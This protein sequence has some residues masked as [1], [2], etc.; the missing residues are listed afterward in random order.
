[1]SETLQRFAPIDWSTCSTSEAFATP[2]WL[3][4]V[5]DWGLYWSFGIND[6]WTKNIVE[7]AGKWMTTCSHNAPMS[8][9]MWTP[10]HTIFGDHEPF[11][12]LR[13]LLKRPLPVPYARPMSE[14]HALTDGDVEE[15]FLM[16]LPF[17]MSY[18]RPNVYGSCA[19]WWRCW[20]K[21]HAAAKEAQPPLSPLMMNVNLLQ[22]I[23]VGHVCFR[24]NWWMHANAWLT[25]RLTNLNG[26]LNW[27]LC[28]CKPY[29]NRKCYA[30]AKKRVTNVCMGDN[31]YCWHARSLRLDLIVWKRWLIWWQIS[32]GNIYHEWTN[33]FYS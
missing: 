10:P 21:L 2:P 16:R 12:L 13:Q 7:T 20:R 33:V 1:M 26:G 5:A 23:I 19:N 29:A 22:Y 3:R 15:N 28:W 6:A 11:Y 32:L 27:L 24:C 8:V 17:P 25:S 31:P 18:A 30:C 14:G 9:P 4:V